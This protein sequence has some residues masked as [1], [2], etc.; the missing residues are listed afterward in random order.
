[1]CLFSCWQVLLPGGRKLLFL[2]I[3]A[4]AWAR[5]PGGK[6][7][8]CC[9][10]QHN[11]EPGRPEAALLGPWPGQRGAQV[12]FRAAGGRDGAPTWRCQPGKD[13]SPCLHPFGEDGQSAHGLPCRPTLCPGPQDVSSLR[14][15]HW[16]GGVRRALPQVPDRW[17]QADRAGR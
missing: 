5:A 8:I 16:P 14:S 7:V 9:E 17:G 3:P 6:R 2:E 12:M 10:L 11:R 15:R 1:M 4:R 13:T